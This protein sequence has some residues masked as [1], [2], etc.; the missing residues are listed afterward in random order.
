[1][2]ALRVNKLFYQDMSPQR[3]DANIICLMLRV[4]KFVIMVLPPLLLQGFRQE[5]LRGGG[6]GGP[7]PGEKKNSF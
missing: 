5:C 3:K 1:M 6:S 4:P 7:P 2:Y